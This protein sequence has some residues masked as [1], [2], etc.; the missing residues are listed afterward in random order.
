MVQTLTV[1]WHW[2][3][4]YSFQRGRWTGRWRDWWWGDWNWGGEQRSHRGD[5]RQGEREGQGKRKDQRERGE[6]PQTLQEALQEDQG[7]EALQEEETWPTE[8]ELQFHVIKLCGT[9]AFLKKKKFFSLSP[10]SAPLPLQQL[11]LR[12]LWL[13]LRSTGTAQEPQGPGLQPRGRR[14]VL[15]GELVDIAVLLSSHLR[16]A[17][18]ISW[19]VFFFFSFPARP[20][21]KGKPR[22]ALATQD[23][24]VWEIQRLQRGQVRLRWRGGRLRRGHVRVRPVQGVILPGSG[25]RSGK[26]APGE[27]AHEARKHEEHETAAVYDWA[28]FYLIPARIQIF[29]KCIC[30]SGSD[31]SE[32]CFVLFFQ[33]VI[34]AGAEEADQAEEEDAGCWWRARSWK[35]NHGWDA[36]EVEEETWAW[37]T[38]HRYQCLPI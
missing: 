21:Y 15:P 8:G 36:A 29:P 32:F 1:Y 37:K 11:Q 16:I 3:S 24:R 31:K 5:R 34:G 28:S 26:R 14:P 22:K 6:E 4:F 20:G 13:G 12:Q 38:W 18:I 17:G 9:E 10:S 7:E 30:V 33:L 35:A 2:P 27:R 25:S 19:L 23:Q